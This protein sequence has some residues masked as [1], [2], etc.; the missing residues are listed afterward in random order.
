MLEELDFD[1]RDIVAQLHCPAT[2]FSYRL[3]STSTTKKYVIMYVLF[4]ASMLR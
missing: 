1:T 2:E 4:A 3:T